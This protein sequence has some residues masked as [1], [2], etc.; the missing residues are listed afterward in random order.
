[1]LFDVISIIMDDLLALKQSCDGATGLAKD[2]IG[3]LATGGFRLPKWMSN[4]REVLTAIPLY[5]M[6]CDIIHL[7]RNRLPQERALGVKWC[8]EQDL[9]SLNPVKSEFPNTK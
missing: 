1:M 4:S 5:E 9:L 7:D 2:L 8:A 3:V 6:V